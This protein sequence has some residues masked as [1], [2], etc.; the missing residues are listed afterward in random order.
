MDL[1]L[2]R[3]SYPGRSSSPSFSISSAART[4]GSTAQGGNVKPLTGNR[5]TLI[6]FGILILAILVA[7]LLFNLVFLV[8]Y[9]LPAV[10]VIGLIVWL[11]ARRRER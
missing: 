11:V 3:R 8:I 6:A 4:G 5:G 10:V 1:R 2:R 7:W 9:A